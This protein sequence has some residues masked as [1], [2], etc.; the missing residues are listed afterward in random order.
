MGQKVN[1]VG[2]RMGINR[3][4]NSKWFA[5]KKEYSQYLVE[6]IAIRRYLEKELASAALSRIEIDRVKTDEGHKVIANIYVARPGDVLGQ[7]GENIKRIRE[8]LK[9]VV[10]TG[11]SDVQVVEVKNPDLDAMLMAKDIASQLENR[12]AFR[13]TMKKSIQRMMRAGAKGC[14]ILCSGRLGG[15]EIAREEGYKEGVVPLTTLRADIDFAHV[16]AHTTYG[17]IGVKVWI[18]RSLNKTDKAYVNE[19]APESS[20]RFDH[21]GPR[22]DHRGPRNGSAAPKQGGDNNAAT[23]AC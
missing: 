18:C 8:G 17:D 1:A 2:L 9:K 20:R 22:P 19:P 14:R 4:W 23:K 7:D 12:A 21:R 5:S 15:A 3:D 16:D 13:T 6:D 10:K 11:S